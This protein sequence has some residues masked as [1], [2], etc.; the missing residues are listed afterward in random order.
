MEN[1]SCTRGL[2]SLSFQMYS[3][4]DL[5]PSLIQAYQDFWVTFHPVPKFAKP[6]QS[7]KYHTFLRIQN[8]GNII[9]IFKI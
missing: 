1:L 4:K 5:K 6:E 8:H 3:E 2:P 7:L 9:A